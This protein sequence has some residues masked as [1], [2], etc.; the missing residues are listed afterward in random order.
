MIQ[1]CASIG[2]Q[3]AEKHIAK[4]NCSLGSHNYY[5]PPTPVEISTHV[6]KYSAIKSN[7]GGQYTATVC[8]R[9][10]SL[11]LWGKKPRGARNC[12]AKGTVEG[13]RCPPPKREQYNLQSMRWHRRTCGCRTRFYCGRRARERCISTVCFSHS[14]LS[15][16]EPIPGNPNILRSSTKYIFLGCMKLYQNK[17]PSSFKGF[18]FFRKSDW[19]T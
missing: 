6:R 11:W 10:C 12:V 17:S 16:S 8:T 15:H 7:N 5:A 9:D 19:Y 4:T 14:Q 1:P 3:Y 2:T 13:V 18:Q